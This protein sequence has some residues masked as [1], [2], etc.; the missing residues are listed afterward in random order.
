MLSYFV[1]YYKRGFIIMSIKKSLQILLILS[2]IVPLIV[3][4]IVI[5]QLFSK[6]LID[7]L[8]KDMLN[9]AQSTTV[10]VEAL[11]N[12]QITEVSLLATQGDVQ[13]LVN[14]SN[15]G[16]SIA[17]SKVITILNS[18]QSICSSINY[19]SVYNLNKEIVS[20][21][22]QSIIGSSSSNCLSLLYMLTTGDICTCV[23]GVNDNTF[24]IG[25]PIF[26]NHSRELIGYIVSNLDTSYLSN[27]ISK[28]NVGDSATGIFLD[29]NGTI[30]YHPDEELIGCTINSGKLSELVNN[31]DKGLTSSSGN[32]QHTYDGVD[33]VLGYSYIPQLNWILIISHDLYGIQYL[34]GIMIGSFISIFILITVF[35]AIISNILA[36]RYT[37]PLISLRDTMRTAAEGNLTAQSNIKGTNELGE[38]SKSFNKMMHIIKNN[39]DELSNMHEEL[40]SNEEQLRSNYDHIEFLAYHDTL[41]SLPN[42]LALLNYADAVLSSSA[43]NGNKQGVYF[44]DLD[45]FKTINDT[46]GHE[47]GDT[48]L[49]KTAQILTTLL[50][51][52]GM[53]ARAGGDEFIIFKENI[54]G[55][56][57]ADAF[58][59][60]IIEYFKSPL[61]LEGEMVYVSMSIGIAV[62]PDDGLSSDVL[63]KNADIAM[64][65][66]KDAG[67]NKF[68]MFDFSMEEE[69]N[70]NTMIIDILHNAI[71]NN[72][73]YIQY[74]P[75]LNI[76]RNEVVGYEA[77]MRINNDKLGNLSPNEFIPVAEET[78][79]IIELSTWLLREACCFNK[80]LIDTGIGPCTLSVNISSIQ[81]NQPNFVDLLSEILEETKFPPRYLEIEI[82]ES[83]LVSSITDA[84][85][86]L[87]ALQN[88]GI[89]ISL[90]DFGTGYSSLNYLTKLPINTLKI[91][92]S[93]IDNICS[94]TKD[95]YISEAIIQLAHSLNIQVVAE[96]VENTN[97]LNVLKRQECDIIQGFIF[98]EPLHPPA[99]I[100]VILE[101]A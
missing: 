12:N 68:T 27:S 1:R 97:Q 72:D 60:K 67:K 98:S 21:T 61:N 39:Y 56:E 101:T 26:D 73:I 41:T 16:H 25:S 52:K 69:L 89:K 86:L 17:D 71:E 81:L 48:L 6:Q 63:I 29:K 35:I 9:V 95:S 87:T 10:N 100:D 30:I 51:E 76:K 36:K 94:S 4:S 18:R 70:R 15:K 14:E 91:D 79:L 40:V 74:Q 57:E 49:I 53:L 88:L 84:T 2:S 22:D 50:G 23:G 77:L 83:T 75:L 82:T 44:I 37:A 34:N 20:S 54:S 66:S 64:Y 47:Y 13:L 59:D 99:L 8:S 93:F 62:Y 43:T 28:I 90:D 11:L 46:L 5:Y 24:S 3:I 92:K 45:N 78:G 33:Q 80:K 65:K 38:L 19:I 31:I 42:K 58:A 55:K 32:F 85:L 7:E 96:G